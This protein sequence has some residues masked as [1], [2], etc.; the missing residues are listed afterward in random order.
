MKFFLQILVLLASAGNAFCQETPGVQ[1]T[2]FE[3]VWERRVGDDRIVLLKDTT[4]QQ[5]LKKSF[6]NAFS[7]K[8]KS[9]V[10]AFSVKVNKL[11]V[12]RTKPKFNP[13][14]SNADTS[15]LYVFLQLFDEAI[16][17]NQS[18]SLKSARIN[19]KYRLINGA[20]N[21][22]EDRSASFNIMKRNPPPG[23]I[24]LNKLPVYPLQLQYAFDTIASTIVKNEARD[25]T[26]IW[27]DATCGYE[28]P[29]VH[30][31]GDTSEF[32]YNTV[33]QSISVTGE[34][35]FTI[36]HDSVNVT[37]GRK[38]KNGFDNTTGALLTL[39]SNI[40]TEKKKSSMYTA[41]HSFSDGSATYRCLVTYTDTKVAERRRTKD[42]NGLSLEMG[43]YQFGWREF[44]QD[45]TQVIT[46]NDDTIALFS[47]QLKLIKEKFTRMWNGKDVSTIENLRPEYSNADK[48]EMEMKGSIEKNTFLLKTSDGGRIKKIKINGEEVFVFFSDGKIVHRQLDARQLKITTLLCLL[49]D[50]YQL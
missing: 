48:M 38:V 42:E 43:E 27:L 15:K 29:P 30:V 47:I 25:G 5:I 36:T 17:I 50:K 22:K 2:S 18:Y 46:M 11:P 10:S 39:F 8:W 14:I 26:E 33:D 1:V 31:K 21:V 16:A 28:E 24:R 7:E 45:V 3:Y 4:Y 23:Q 32:R 41:E 19:V 40:D 49:S 35:V 37:R 6:V 12:F 44:K 9:D 20:G 34:N 13:T